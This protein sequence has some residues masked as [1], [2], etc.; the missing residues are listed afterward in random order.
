MEVRRPYLGTDRR[1][2]LMDRRRDI[3]HRRYQPWLPEGIEIEKASILFRDSL[4][5]Y[6][7]NRIKQRLGVNDLNIQV[8]LRGDAGPEKVR[9]GEKIEDWLRGALDD[10]DPLGRHDGK[11]REHQAGDGEG[12][13]Q[14]EFLPDYVPPARGEE[15]DGDYDDLVN[16]GRK[17]WGIPLKLQSPDPRSLYVPPGMDKLS[18]VVKVVNRPLIDVRDKWASQG[19]VLRS[20]DQGRLVRSLQQTGVLAPAP[21]VAEYGR[22]VRCVEIADS[23][24]IYQCVFPQTAPAGP[25]M[26]S[27]R[28]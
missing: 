5:E 11:V 8:S 14:L 21:T 28:S 4:P 2:S 27:M 26:T 12:W 23:D 10:L 17:T 22:M 16:E 7:I 3:R 6:V 24:Y 20:D 18:L 15:P 1:D 9:K 13:V 19:L 25:R